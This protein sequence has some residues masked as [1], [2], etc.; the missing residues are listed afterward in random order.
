MRKRCFGSVT[1]VVA[2]V[3]LVFLAAGSVGAQA[4]RTSAKPWDPPRTPDGQPDIQGF[5]SE[6]P[7]GADAVNVETGLQTADSLRIQQ[8][9]TT[10]QLA[11]R[12]TFSAVVD[13]PDGRIPYQPW[14]EAR[15]QQILRRYGG[16]DRTEEPQSPRD[17]TSEL[18]CTLGLP[19]IVYFADFQVVQT[20]GYV[21]MSWERTR[22]Y[23]LIPLDGHPHIP[24]NVKLHMGD[25]RGNWEGNTLVVNTTNLNDWGWIDSKGTIHTDAM[26]LL[27]RYTFADAN[28]ID[29]RVTIQDPKALTRPLT[30]AF[31]FKRAHAQEKDYELMEN[32][33]YEG[34]RA[35]ESI[36]GRK[37]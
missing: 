2:C 35:F 28:T 31:T 1:A 8:A 6:E 11:A 13:P 9:L 15:R 21:V 26:S 33:C 19:R 29:Y 20:P 30:I 5:W 24:P 22:E 16:D 18:L 3:A 37:R 25:A 14:A 4:P 27:E 10:A 17:V 32:A 34:E 36:L 23:R 7:G 12:K